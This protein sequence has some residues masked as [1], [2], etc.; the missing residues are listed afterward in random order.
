MKIFNRALALRRILGA[1]TLLIFV[2]WVG[3]FWMFTLG[4]PASGDRSGTLDIGGRTRTYFVHVPSHYDGHKPL[5]LVFVLHGATQSPESAEQ[6]SGMSAKADR[7]NFLTVYPSGTGR[8]SRVPTWNSGACCSYAMEHNVDDVA[9]LRALIKKLERDYA[10][11]PKRI[12]FTGISNGGMMSYRAACEM[13]DEVAAVAPVEG[14][15]DLACHPSNP[16]SVLVFHGTADH[17]VPF[18]GGS[19]PFQLGSKRSDTP[20]A[21]AVA[22]WVK[23]D[24]CSPTPRHEETTV[25]HS[26]K[27]S[28]CKDGSAVTLYAIQGGHHAWPGTRISGNDVSATDLIWTFFEQHPKP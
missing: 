14:A 23:Q 3:A 1:L 12:Y 22:F 28:G 7:E 18:D 26:D 8:L 16:V 4:A 27:Y 25:V 11:D 21:D 13:S 2:L 9:F 17:L 10:V 15:Q 5:P 19:T 24:G 6:M 20:V